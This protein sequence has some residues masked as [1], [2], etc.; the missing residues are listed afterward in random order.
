MKLIEI[1]KADFILTKYYLLKK[2]LPSESFVC[3]VGRNDGYGYGR[4]QSDKIFL[5]TMKYK[6]GNNGDCGIITGWYCAARNHLR[7]S[8]KEVLSVESQLTQLQLHTIIPLC[9]D[10]KQSKRRLY[11]IHD[12]D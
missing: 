5:E 8:S 9:Q 6:S 1:S 7:E 11:L 2:P 12:R 4:T 3:V 10:E